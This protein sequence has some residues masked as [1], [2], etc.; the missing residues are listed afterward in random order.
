MQGGTQDNK[1]RDARIFLG[2]SDPERGAVKGFAENCNGISSSI[3]DGEFHPP[4]NY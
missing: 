1:T 4:L 3:K 2:L